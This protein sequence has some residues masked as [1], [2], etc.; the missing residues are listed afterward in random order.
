MKTI[1][2]MQPYLFAY[3]PYFQ[4]AHAVDEFW[5]LDDVQF[6]RRGWMNR[7][8]ILLNGAE[9]VITFPVAHGQQEDLIA[10]KRLAAGFD[11]SLNRLVSTLNHAYGAAAHGPW[12]HQMM[13]TLA[14]QGWS[15]FLPLAQAA[16]QLCFDRLGLATPVHLASTLRLAPDLRGQARILALCQAQGATRYINPAGGRALYQAAAF[17][18]HGIKLRFL[19]GH[20]APYPHPSTSGFVAGLSILDLIAHLGPEDLARQ[21]RNYELLP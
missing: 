11:Q 5:L 13:T 12:V 14:G 1:C 9:H 8:R 16:L 18:D 4:L 21:L 3:L 15:R 6:I 10:D 2:A 17:A 7:N 20:C 19:Q